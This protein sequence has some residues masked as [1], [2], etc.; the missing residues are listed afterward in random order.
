MLI[1]GDIGGTKTHVALL[2]SPKDVSDAS[3][4]G[5]FVASEKYPSSQYA[6]LS[7]I[8][9]DF[10][11]RFDVAPRSV[12]RVCAG[13]AGPVVEGHVETPNLPWD[14]DA[15]ELRT[16][17]GVAAV[18]LMNDLEATAERA[19]TL[20][21]DDVLVLNVVQSR[22]LARRAHRGQAVGALLDVPLDQLLQGGEVDL[23]VLERG[24]EGDRDAGEHLP[25]GPD[26]ALPPRPGIGTV[27]DGGP[28][29][30][31]PWFF[32]SPGKK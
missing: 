21:G 24:D 25:L 5:V 15:T 7:A 12:K 28:P 18:T 20:S 32:T 16:S 2:D 4:K 17:L 23:T 19:A 14:V 27:T 9:S 31:R 8:L 22:R 3:R 6:G 30:L 29:L 26:H 1:A 10:M 13:V 11:R